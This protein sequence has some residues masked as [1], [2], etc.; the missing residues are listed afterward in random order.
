[1]AGASAATRSAIKLRDAAHYRYL[2]SSG[3]TTIEGVD[4]AAEFARVENALV[5]L[6]IPQHEQIRAW[7]VLSALLYLG[8][9]EFQGASRLA[10]PPVKS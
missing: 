6:G 7:S 3:C 2:A 5:N 9:V 10:R 8:N 1:M 4:D